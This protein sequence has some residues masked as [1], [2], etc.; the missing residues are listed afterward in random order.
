MGPISRRTAP[1]LWAD[2]SPALP[3]AIVVSALTLTDLEVQAERQADQVLTAGSL[4]SAARAAEERDG[5]HTVRAAVV[6][7][8]VGA[9]LQGL[10]SVQDGAPNPDVVGPHLAGA[11]P[12][13]VFVY[14]HTG[15]ADVDAHTPR[16]RLA[17]YARGVLTAQRALTTHSPAVWEPGQ[18]LTLRTRQQ[19]AFVWQVALTSLLTDRGILPHNCLGAGWGKPV[20]A[21][22]RGHLPL[23]H[24]AQWIHHPDDGPH[25]PEPLLA[26]VRAA[27]E[28]T[29]FVEIAPRP[30][31]AR[32]LR[33]AAA[34]QHHVSI[35]TCDPVE[36]A[37]A[38]GELYTL[39]HPYPPRTPADLTRTLPLPTAAL[40]HDWVA[41]YLMRALR[42]HAHI[43]PGTLP[44]MTWG[45]ADLSERQLVRLVHHLRQVP[46]WAHLTTSD[47]HPAISVTHTAD[48]LSADP[49]L[50]VS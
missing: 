37:H 25:D 33:D 28:P 9:A 19:A 35:L 10:R 1:T 50:E 14:P 48:W 4:A 32:A 38:F 43:P 12:R 3:E 26:E 47:L 44:S 36:V 42:R 27:T 40:P 24:A 31:L 41:P 16:L 8:D 17:A 23:I 30:V 7:S 20:A 18:P 22:A 29:V 39:G 13:I 15:D 46:A 49:T 2:R 45:Q 34:P 6:A 21:Y 5:G 11:P